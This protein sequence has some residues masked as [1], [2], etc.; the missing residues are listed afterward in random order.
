MGKV[1]MVE[2]PLFQETIE[3][4][5]QVLSRLDPKPT[6]SLSSMLS[7]ANSERIN[8][9]DVTQPL[10]TAIQ[11]AL[12]DL[13]GDWNIIPSVSIGHSSGEIAPH[14]QQVSL[15]PQRQ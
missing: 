2:F 3:R 6:F 1:A 14:M 7:G 11:I 10:C 5:D 12:V 4:L 8:D 9:A 13:F 15:A